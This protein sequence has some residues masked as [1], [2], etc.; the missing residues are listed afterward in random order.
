MINSEQI[1][2]ALTSSVFVLILLLFG[3]L[4]WFSIP[5]FVSSPV[6][7]FSLEWQPEAGL[8]G[9]MPMVAGSI[10]LGLTAL[11]L[12]FPVAVGIC[13]FCL[14]ER[15]HGLAVW[16]RRLIRLMAGIPTVVYGL[17][18]IFV[19]VPLLREIFRSGSGFCLLAAVI[20]IVLLILPVM[21]TMLDNHCQPL[22][23]QIRFA[24]Y[25]MGFSDI[26]IVY[27]LVL[28]HCR[29]GMLAAALLG[30]NRAIGD[31]LLPLMLAG[32]A[33]QLTGNPLD[34][35]RVLTAHIG[36]VISTESGSAAYNS[37]F[38]AGLLLLLISVSVTL[39][40]KYMERHS[41]TVSTN[42]LVKQVK[43]E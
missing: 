1:L 24:S 3:F 27:H 9:I 33:P 28:P 25:A 26:Q 14:I 19:L 5:V 7:L 38:A 12:A 32:N 23:Q 30:F 43:Q 11:L 22:A 41:H 10:S 20:M 36:L 40:I 8:Y 2:L 6:A 18:A 37:L 39:L 4:F 35:I 29:Q 16:V 31:T 21:V 42:S 13:G 34:S 15:Y 17:T